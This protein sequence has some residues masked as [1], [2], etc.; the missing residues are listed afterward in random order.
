MTTA[1][2]STNINMPSDPDTAE[3]LEAK[4]LSME[5]HMEVSFIIWAWEYL[6]QIKNTQKSLHLQMKMFF[7]LICSCK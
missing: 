6:G 4:V 1:T 5:L 2:Q 3:K 7:K